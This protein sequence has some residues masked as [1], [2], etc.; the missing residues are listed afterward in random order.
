LEFAR[1]GFNS[2]AAPAYISEIASEDSRKTGWLLPIYAVSW[3]YPKLAYHVHSC[4]H[5][6][7]VQNDSALAWWVVEAFPA[8]PFIPYCADRPQKAQDGF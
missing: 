2:W 4:T 1:R 7:W 6:M 3:R 8:I 5:S